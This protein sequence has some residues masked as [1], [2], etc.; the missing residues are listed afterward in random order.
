MDFVNSL[1]P[2]H[3][4]LLF[5]CSS[6]FMIWRLGAMEHHG[7]HGTVLG[8]LIMP[9]CSGF[10][11]LSFAFVLGCYGGEGKIVLEN[12]IVNNVTNLSLL[13]GLPA[14]FWSLSLQSD[15]SIKK[16]SKKTIQQ[17][18]L[19]FLSLIFTLIALFFFTGILWAL[20]KDGEINFGDGVTLVAIF[21][22]WQLIHVFE[23]LKTNLQENRTLSPQIVVELILIGASAYGMYVS[24]D[25]LVAWVGDNK[26]G[27]FVF[28]HLGWLSGF[29]MVL[30]N[31]LL[32]MYYGWRGRPDIVYSSQLGDG[33]ICIPMCIGL[34]ALFKPIHIPSFFYFGIILIFLTGLVHFF[35]LV[36]FKRLPK[37]IGFLLIT[38]YVSFIYQSFLADSI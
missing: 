13:L 25:H 2:L 10:S 23:V 8:T 22:F 21:V 18:R 36:F 26:S 28:K 11:N 7:F 3:H 15:S 33:H 27:L 31:G 19:T 16:Q 1:Y 6:A 29:L 12:C 20:A 4:V 30:P 17:Y 38:S 9:Y 34:F 35:F 32:S 5:L 37:L 14:I 24:I